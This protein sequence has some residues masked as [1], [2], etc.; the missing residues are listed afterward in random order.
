[1]SKFK[2]GDICIVQNSPYELEGRTNGSIVTVII[3]RNG[4]YTCEVDNNMFP[5]WDFNERML[6]KMTKLDKILK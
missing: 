5:S 4:V 1:M 3:Q 2:E 6:R